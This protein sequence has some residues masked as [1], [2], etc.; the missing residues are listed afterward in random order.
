[1]PH[2]VKPGMG[3]DGQFG[4]STPRGDALLSSV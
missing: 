3:Y 2:V 1:M 4:G